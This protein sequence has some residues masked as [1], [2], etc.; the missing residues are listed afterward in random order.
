MRRLAGRTRFGL[1]FGCFR[2]LISSLS[3]LVLGCLRRT[4][5]FILLRFSWTGLKVPGFM[6]TCFLRLVHLLAAF[7][8]LIMARL[9][10]RGGRPADQDD[11]RG[12]R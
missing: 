7:G 2:T 12:T 9:R 6:L 1:A 8:F 10:H 11:G 4:R 5:S 3:C